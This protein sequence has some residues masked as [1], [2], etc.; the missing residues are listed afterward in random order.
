MSFIFYSNSDEVLE[1]L[2][3]NKNIW[4]VRT[5]RVKSSLENKPDEE[6]VKVLSW[7]LFQESPFLEI[8]LM[9]FRDETGNILEGKEVKKLSLDSTLFGIF[10]DENKNSTSFNAEIISEQNSNGYH[11]ELKEANIDEDI[12]SPMLLPDYRRKET[13]ARMIDI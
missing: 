9:I 6:Y 5:S 10:Y 11:I 2:V 8:K 4:G 12:T 1:D 13:I 3:F 7:M